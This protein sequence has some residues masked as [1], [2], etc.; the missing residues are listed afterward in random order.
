[1]RDGDHI[2]R[3][4]DRLDEF[5][6]V[7]D[8]RK[9]CFVYVGAAY[10]DI[11]A[12]SR[13]P[14]YDDAS[15]FFGAIA[16][17]HRE[18]IRRAFQDNDKAYDE[19]YRVCRPDG[20]TRLVRD[21]AFPLLGEHE[22]FEFVAGLAS[23]LT[24]ITDELEA[25]RDQLAQAQ[26]M[27]LVGQL[28]GGVAHDFNN[29]LSVIM[30]FAEFV[31]MRLHEDS[32]LRDDVHKIMEASESAASL[33]RRLLTFARREVV[34][35]EVVEPG[36]L[37]ERIRPLLE[38][39]LPADIALEAQIAPRLRPIRMAPVEVEQI[40]MNLGIN[41]RDAMPDGGRL[42]IEAAN[43]EKSPSS[44]TAPAELAYGRYV[45]IRVTDTG[46]GMDDETRARIFEPFF[47]TKPKNQ[48]T[49]LGLATVSN[50]VG[51]NGGLIRVDSQLGRGTS[52]ELYF[53]EAERDHDDAASTTQDPNLTP[54]LGGETILVVD[55]QTE[56]REL[57]RRILAPA[58]Y[59]V[60]CAASGDQALAMA[61][62][63]DDAIDLLLTD[64]VM[65]GIEGPELAER[66]REMYG[67]VAVL[68]TSGFVKDPE[69]R[70]TLREQNA[71][72]IAKPFSPNTLLMKVLQVL[73]LKG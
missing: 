54:D 10:E 1:M 13:Q 35:S 67:R 15:E 70:D 32:P 4:V 38:R 58:G 49:G 31:E 30:G 65:P 8:P 71:W 47:T 2:Q 66:L 39:T 44:D 40:V 56:V 20:T 21:R 53:P 36:P 28:A 42:T 37:L 25:T 23:D 18:R 33:V 19:V 27:E 62:D 41:A 46:V 64:I 22:R 9:D 51:Q 7:Y 50:L 73:A 6:W 26:K 11:W 48:G 63:H 24:A 5:F 43:M 29:L 17:D 60:L 52:F 55:D 12:R 57:V 34:S 61:R 3:Q 14:L 69:T 45:Y 16:D 68:Y 72:F 59:T